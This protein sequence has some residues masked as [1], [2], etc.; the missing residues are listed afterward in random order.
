MTPDRCPRCGLLFPL[1]VQSDVRI[2]MYCESP[3]RW[4][5]ARINRKKCARNIVYLLAV[6]VPIMFK[7]HEEAV[8]Y[9][10][11]LDW[12]EDYAVS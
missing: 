7:E 4:S 9:R 1:D 10:H 3:T 12:L 5:K 8:M 11:M 2:H 6:F